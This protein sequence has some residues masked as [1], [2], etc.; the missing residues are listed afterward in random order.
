[1]TLWV[2]GDSYS[3]DSQN[4]T[5]STNWQTIDKSWTE[6][7]V[8][9]L[10]VSK[11]HV[12]ARPG[13]SNEWI[14]GQLLREKDNFKQDDYVIIQPTCS[15][16]KWLIE[17]F[18]E[19]SNWQFS[20]LD[21][22]LTKNEINALNLYQRYLIN[23]EINLYNY[24]MVI[25][26]FMF[27]AQSIPSV[28]ILII[29]GFH[30]ISGIT[31]SLG[32]VCFGE[33]V[34]STIEDKYYHYHKNDPRINHM[35]ESNHKILAKKIHDFFILNYLVDLTSGF[36]SKFINNSNYRENKCLTP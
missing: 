3:V 27:I 6:L 29:P 19:I 16:R 30:N 17:R 32:N 26:A 11:K 33:F 18:P 36:E 22:R 34:N 7:L 5:G 25:R 13:V 2:F 35:H 12:I 8:D 14:Y 9:L 31:G 20:S 21:K 4:T 28:K 15:S 24:D 23:D 10:G 1:M